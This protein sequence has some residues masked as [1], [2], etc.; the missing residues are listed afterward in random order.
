MDKALDCPPPPPRTDACLDGSA[1]VLVAIGAQHEYRC[2]A[3]LSLQAAIEAKPL[4]LSKVAA[5][6]IGWAR[7]EVD[8][9]FQARDWNAQCYAPS[10]K[11]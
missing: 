10:T 7:K 8:L 4:D 11:S 6:A 9:R 3:P 1:P 2:P 5:E